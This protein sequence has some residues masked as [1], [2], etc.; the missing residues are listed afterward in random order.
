DDAAD[1]T[2]QTVPITAS[3][4]TIGAGPVFDYSGASVQGMEF[5]GGSGADTVNVTGLP[6]GTTLAMGSS[7]S[8]Q[9]N[10]GDASHAVD[11]FYSVSITGTTGLTIDDAAD[12]TAQ[13]IFIGS[14]SVMFDNPIFDYSGATL[15]SFTFDGGTAADTV[16]VSGT[17]TVTGSI[18][19][20]MGTSTSN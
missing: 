3:S 17:P 12:A 19:L 7:T 18:A 16:N 20:N 2:G 8:N 4:L 15:Q 6:S 1:A 13:L 10:I 14:S 5:D 11:N 9:V